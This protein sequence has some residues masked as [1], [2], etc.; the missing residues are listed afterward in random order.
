MTILVLVHEACY[1]IYFTPLSKTQKD[2]AQ[3][4][5]FREGHVQVAKRQEDLTDHILQEYDAQPREAVLEAQPVPLHQK[6]V[7]YLHHSNH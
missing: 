7:N 4:L 1:S 2:S 5:S 6:Y 3:P